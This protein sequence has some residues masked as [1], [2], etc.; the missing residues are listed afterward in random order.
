MAEDRE[1]CDYN[2]NNLYIV[3]RKKE[4]GDGIRKRQWLQDRQSTNLYEE[5]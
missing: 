3:G 2:P 1:I 4:T 5:G